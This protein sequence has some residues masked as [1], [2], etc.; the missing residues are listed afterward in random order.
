[1]ET[2]SAMMGKI[3]SSKAKYRC[4]SLCVVDST[5]FDCS[6]VSSKT[7]C[8]E[9]CGKGKRFNKM[10]LYNH[11]VACDDGDQDDGDGCSSG[12]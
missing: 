5:N 11:L 7:V 9:K 3:L 4:S 2:R 12:C 1:M 8:Y 10:S 6:E